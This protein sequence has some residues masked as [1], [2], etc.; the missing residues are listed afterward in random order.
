VCCTCGRSSWRRSSSSSSSSSSMAAPAKQTQQQ[1]HTAACSNPSR[2]N[3]VLWPRLCGSAT[4]PLQ[5][6]GRSARRL[7]W[8]T[9]AGTSG[10]QAWSRAATTA[11]VRA[12]SSCAAAH[13]ATAGQAT[14][15]THSPQTPPIKSPYNNRI[16]SRGRRCAAAA[17]VRG[18]WSAVQGCGACGGHSGPGV[19]IQG[20]WSRQAGSTAQGRVGA[21]ESTETQACTRLPAMRRRPCR[22]CCCCC[23]LPPPPP[24]APVLARRSDSGD[25]GK[26]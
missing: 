21:I 17:A 24:S 16:Q 6:C 14:G 8:T 5:Q 12:L 9:S 11:L 25:A 20:G 13:A 23:V 22:C 4:C 1:K 19:F 3:A 15:H 26:L 18:R 2:R 7:L 10:Q